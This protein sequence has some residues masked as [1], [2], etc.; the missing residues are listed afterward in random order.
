M[1]T[2]H[3]LN[4]RSPI[5]PRT[6]KPFAYKAYMAMTGSIANITRAALR[7]GA[8]VIGN[9][10]LNGNA[11]F[12]H[13]TSTLNSYTDAAE[14]Q[15]WINRDSS[16]ISLPEWQRI[17]Q[18]V[19]DNRRAGSWMLVRAHCECPSPAPASVNRIFDLA[20]Y[21]LANTGHAFY[22]FTAGKGTIH[23]WQQWVPLYDLNLGTPTQTYA[24]AGQYFRKGVYQRA[25]HGGLVL[26]NPGTKSVRVALSHAYHTL[27]GDT[28]TAVTV[29]AHGAIILKT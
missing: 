11:Y 19:I 21:L 16:R 26:V 2:H 17:V 9:G 14:A 24:T 6:H 5:D 10:Y 25:Y 7:S 29:A 1:G 20:T 18:M 15:G 3:N 8:T 12:F 13:A 28:T 22:D 27:G 4:G 23:A